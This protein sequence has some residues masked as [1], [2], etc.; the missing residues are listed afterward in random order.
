MWHFVLLYELYKQPIRT[1]QNHR[2]VVRYWIPIKI[3]K[4]EMRSQQCITAPNLG[5]L[6]LIRVKIFVYWVSKCN[7]ASI[8]LNSWPVSVLVMDGWTSVP[9]CLLTSTTGFSDDFLVPVTSSENSHTV[10]VMLPQYT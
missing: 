9:I 3:V 2:S 7:R 8:E 10:A 1:N 6:M 4:S 5:L